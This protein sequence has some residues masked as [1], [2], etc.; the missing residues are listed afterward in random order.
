LVAVSGVASND[1]SKCEQIIV[2]K[3]VELL[4]D[5]AISQIRLQTVMGGKEKHPR[6]GMLIFT[7]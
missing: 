3:L 4:A 7:T 1:N 6:K 2:E 5:K